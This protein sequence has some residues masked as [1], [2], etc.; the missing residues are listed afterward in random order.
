MAVRGPPRPSGESLWAL[1][2]GAFV[3][4]TAAALAVAVGGCGAAGVGLVSAGAITSPKSAH[5][6]ATLLCRGYARFGLREAMQ[7]DLAAMCISCMGIFSLSVFG[8]KFIETLWQLE[9]HVALLWVVS[10]V[11]PHLV[12]CARAVYRFALHWR[13]HVRGAWHRGNILGRG[14]VVTLCTLLMAFWLVPAQSTYVE[15]L[16]GD[17]SAADAVVDAMRGV[18][19]RLPSDERRSDDSMLPTKRE[20]VDK[21][22]NCTNLRFMDL[23]TS[24]DT[25]ELCESLG[26]EVES[27]PMC[28]SSVPNKSSVVSKLCILDTRSEERRVGK[29]CRL[30]WSPYH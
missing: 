23:L 4:M 14:G 28:S 15:P 22:E 5:E 29:E 25:C 16:A 21:I 11:T 8:L 10:V 9:A 2:V 17:G 26:V 30:R 27:V 19:T 3:L 20:M 24:R 1:A 6:G 7:G 12:R 13:G 18:I